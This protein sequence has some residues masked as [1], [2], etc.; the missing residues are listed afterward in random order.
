MANNLRILVADDN[1]S[2]RTGFIE[3][4]NNQD[5]LRVIGEAKNGLEAIE[6]TNNLKPDIIMMDVSMP[7]M[8]GITSAGIIKQKNPGTNVVVVTI[9]EEQIFKELSEQL[10]ADGYICKSSISSDLPKI[11]KKLRNRTKP[12][13]SENIKIL[14]E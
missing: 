7:K 6:L 11:L 13:E 4:I 12:N 1:D 2:F 10:P 8:D 9:H 3:Y 14:K 5:G